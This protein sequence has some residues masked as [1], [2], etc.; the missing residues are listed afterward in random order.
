M[1]VSS[2]FPGGA[3]SADPGTTLEKPSLSCKFLSLETPTSV[4]CMFLLSGLTFH[5]DEITPGGDSE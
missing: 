5:H 3:E 2:E 4:G 1:Y